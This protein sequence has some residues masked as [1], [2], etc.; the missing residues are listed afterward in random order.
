MRR[1]SAVRV[2]AAVLAIFWGYLFFGLIDLAVVFD[3]TPGFYESYLLETGWGI[4]YSFLVAA[5][6]VGWCSSPA[7]RP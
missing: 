7:G 3:R 6:L 4:L 5:P 1:I 2:L